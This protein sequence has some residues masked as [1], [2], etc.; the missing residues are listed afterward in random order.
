MKYQSEILP[1]LAAATSLLLSA[2]GIGQDASES[3][4]L[5]ATPYAASA[6]Y[7]LVGWNDLGM[8]CFDGKDYSIFAVL[9]P[10]NTIHTHLMDPT[11]KL[12]KSGVGYT[13]TYQAV[14]DP[15]TNSIKYNICAKD[16]LLAVRAKVRVGHLA[17]RPGPQGSLDARSTQRTSTDDVQQRGQH[18]HRGWHSHHTLR[19]CGSS[20]VP[21]ELLSHDAAGR[22]KCF[23]YDPSDD[24]HRPAH[25]G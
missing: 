13:V 18:I 8:H 2:A 22:E 10:Y 25:L 9:P 4:V 17:A 19:R 7:K 12:I 24:R 20:T 3:G 5:W 21:A 23:R 14:L 16:Q 6:G 11:G 15:L 1:F